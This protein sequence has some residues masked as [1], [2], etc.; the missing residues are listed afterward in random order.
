MNHINKQKGAA[1][2][3]GM[4]VLLIMT[5]LGISSMRTTTTEL[6]IA[7]NDQ[8]Y[9]TSFQA[10]AS[11]FEFALDGPSDPA[12]GPNIDWANA[13]DSSNNPVTQTVINFNNAAL[14]NASASADA[15]Y[16]DC[17]KVV[18]GSS[19]RGP[20]FR[21]LVHEI[22]AI[23]NATNSGGDLLATSR[24]TLGVQTIRPGCPTL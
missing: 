3:V 12:T 21:G 24:Q 17:R 7:S 16:T 8:A 11:I 6:K 19:L 20:A 14:N 18:L 15:V 23:G 2:V 5:L 10:A 4:V 13:I 1:L 22:R 9:N